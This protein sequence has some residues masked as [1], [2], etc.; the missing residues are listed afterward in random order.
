MDKS[1]Q[2]KQPGKQFLAPLAKSFSIRPLSLATLSLL[3]GSLVGLEGWP[4]V[5]WVALLVAGA[6]MVFCGVLTHPGRERSALS[7]GLAVLGL[8]AFFAAVG[9]VG[10]SC[11]KVDFLLSRERCSLEGVVTRVVR[12]DSLS[13]R[14]VVEAE[15]FE[16]ESCHGSGIGAMVTVPLAALSGHDGSLSGCRISLTGR[17]KV[18]YPD[19][20]SDFDYLDYLT[21]SGISALVEADA[22]ADVRQGGFSLAALAGRIN[23]WFSAALS[24]SG[25]SEPNVAF[26]RALV[27]ADRSDLSAS[28]SRAFSACGTS[29]VLAVSGLHV[30]VLSMA[31]VWLL[32]FFMRR[33]RAS[34]VSVPVIWAYALLAGAS[35]SIVRSAV[36]FSFF[37]IERAAERPLP[38]FQAFWAALFVILLFDPSAAGSAS[39][40]LSFSAVGG[41]LAVLPV[42]KDWL[43]ELRK[44]V[45]IVVSSLL[46]SVVA[47]LATLPILLLV[48]HSVPVYF[49]LNNLI[50]VEPIK[51]VFELSLLCPLTSVVPWVGPAVG[52]CIDALLNFL[53]GYCSWAAT[54]PMATIDNVPC[55]A[56]EFVALSAVVCAG[57][58]VLRRRE[59]AR[60]WLF[61]LSVVGV[62]IVVPYCAGLRG[63]AAVEAFEYRGVAGVV[64][65]DGC[66]RAHFLVD[67][68][69]REAAAG[70]ARKVLAR[71][72]WDSFVVDTESALCVAT[73][74]GRSYAI[75]SSAEVDSI[76]PCDVCIVNCNAEAPLAGAG[77]YV[78]T[79]NCEARALW[80]D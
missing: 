6:V 14:V 37:A 62:A 76:P 21:G 26:L 29:H 39:L 57:F 41:L 15:R 51:W 46:V 16:S 19:P 63:S 69:D 72:G 24:T 64:V 68:A 23:E 56:V 1:E 74:D 59:R 47:Q 22:V 7:E 44:P 50:V 30:G 80:E 61:G 58:Y 32:S 70:V 49:W 73:F 48:F 65:A 13:V 33:S 12:R 55:G 18:P 78:F 4:G 9:G 27:L 79:G 45:R 3:A 53:T 11:S 66:G 40:W 25:V 35:P 20:L 77:G 43:D 42:C 5:P 34:A 38:S 75:V 60:V 10:A 52:W 28:V 36:M 54:L 71:R 17:T 67:G 31:V 8:V 2:E